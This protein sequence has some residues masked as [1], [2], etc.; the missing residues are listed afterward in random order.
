MISCPECN[1]TEY[2]LAGNRYVGSKRIQRYLCRI[3]GYRFSEKNVLSKTRQTGS[4][5]RLTTFQQGKHHIT[6]PSHS[7][8]K[9][10]TLNSILL[11]VASHFGIS[12]EELINRLW[13][14]QVRS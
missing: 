2:V 5:I 11:E 3:C 1:S 6:I 12:K 13:K 7:P 9:I 8:I 4:H 14:K 10:G